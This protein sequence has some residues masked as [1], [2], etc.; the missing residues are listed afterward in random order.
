MKY[1]TD[2]I[3]GKA[4]CILIFFYFPDSRLSVLNDCIFIFDGVTVRAENS[5]S[6]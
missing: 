5:L 4:F 1:C 6:T 2:L 3:L